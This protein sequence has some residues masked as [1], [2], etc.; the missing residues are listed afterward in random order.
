M[1]TDSDSAQSPLEFTIHLQAYIEMCRAR[2]PVRAIAYAR[3]HLSPATA[4]EL[5]SSSGSGSSGDEG[6]VDGNNGQ[7]GSLM[8]EL[9][10]AMAL[11]AYPPDTTCR[12]YQVRSP[13]P[14]HSTPSRSC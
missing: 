4:A 11:L 8:S 14:P 12:V 10:R 3:K 7:G 9:S 5:E 6:G 1:L 2:D 13:R